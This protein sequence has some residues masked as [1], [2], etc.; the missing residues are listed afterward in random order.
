[1]FDILNILSKDHCCYTTFN[2]FCSKN[3]I[4][5]IGYIVSVGACRGGETPGNSAGLTF[6][7]D[8]NCLNRC[9]QDSSCSGYTLPVDG[10]NWCET[11]TSVGVTGDG[12]NIIQCFT[13]GNWKFL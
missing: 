6:Y 7:Q 3:H 11:F 10:D 5:V 1:M 4:C 8:R 13:K 9:N 2:S 12:W